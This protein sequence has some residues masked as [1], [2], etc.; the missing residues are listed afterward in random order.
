MLIQ[1][2]IELNVEAAMLKVTVGTYVTV[3][4]PC[5]VFNIDGT[6]MKK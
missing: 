1:Q 4:H 6:K 2:R 3:F 5:G